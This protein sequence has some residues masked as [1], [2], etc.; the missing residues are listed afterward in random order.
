MT[1]IITIIIYNKIICVPQIKRSKSILYACLICFISML[2][3]MILV[4]GSLDFSRGIFQKIGK[5][6]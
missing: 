6:E 2:T 3:S 5:P 1:L 4:Q